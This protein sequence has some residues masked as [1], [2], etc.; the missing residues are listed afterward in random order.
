MNLRLPINCNFFLPS[1]FLSSTLDIVPSTLDPRLKPRLAAKTNNADNNT[2]QLSSTNENK[3][4]QRTLTEK[5]R[6]EKIRHLKDNQTAILSVV[7]R[8]RELTSLVL[9]W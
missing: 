8:K 9:H 5:G 6:Q 4:R 7:S 1:T 2:E 3:T